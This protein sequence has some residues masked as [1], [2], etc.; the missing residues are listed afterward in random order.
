VLRWGL[1][2]EN[3]AW[4]AV[5]VLLPISCVYYPVATLPEWLRP[6]AWSLPPTHVFEGLRALVLQG[7]FRG[8]LMVSALL[9]NVGYFIAGLLVFRYF[10]QSARENGS[11]VQMGE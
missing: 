1:G 8:D 5:F 2:A 11:L 10:L 4:L 7:V 3:L 9:L 6:L